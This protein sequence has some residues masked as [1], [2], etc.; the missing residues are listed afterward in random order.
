MADQNENPEEIEMPQ[1][2]QNPQNEVQGPPDVVPRER[3]PDVVPRLMHR[4]WNWSFYAIV[5]FVVIV[6]AML[7]IFWW[8]SNKHL[9]ESSTTDHALNRTISDKHGEGGFHQ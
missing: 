9:F 6:I 5:A 3:E 2:G 1:L 8:F 4:Y 7:L